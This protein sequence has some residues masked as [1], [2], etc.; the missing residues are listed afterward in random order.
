VHS[1][2]KST[3]HFVEHCIAEFKASGAQD[4]L[5]VF[6]NHPLDS[7]VIDLDRVIAEEAERLGLAGRV[8]FVETGKLVPLLEKSISAIAINSTACHQALIRRIPTLVLGKAVFNHKQIVSRMRLADFFRMR[9]VK[10]KAAYEKLIA[11]MRHTCQFNGGFYSEE[12][13][14]ILLP[15]LTRALLDGMPDIKSFEAESGDSA[16]ASVKQA[17]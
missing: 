2:F 13:R 16:G 8:F 12:G 17:S 4:S 15:I 14:R 10:G 5:L 6:K 11:V 7:G 3:R 1:E 9:P